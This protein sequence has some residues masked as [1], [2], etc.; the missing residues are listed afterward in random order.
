MAEKDFYSELFKQG[1]GN[2][3]SRGFRSQIT[4]L[5]LVIGIAAIVSL[6]SLGESLNEA[7]SG[8]FEQLGTNTLTVL[9]GK[10]FADTAFVK[11]MENDSKKIE[12]VRGV[13]YANDIFITTKQIQYRNEYKTTLVLGVPGDKIDSMVKIGFI[14]LGEGKLLDSR[15]KFATMIGANFA[16]KGFNESLKLR[17]NIK[18]DGVP[19][20]IIGINKQSKN[21]AGSFLNN[22]VIINNDTLQGISAV[23]ILPSRIMVKILDNYPIDFAKKDIIKVLKKNHDNTEDFQ[24]LD[25][26]QVAETAT[27]VIGLIQL[28]F[29]GIA[30]ISLLIGGI[31]IMNSML[32]SVT[33]RTSEIGLMKVLG[34]TDNKVLAI[35]LAE[36]ALVGIIGGII[37]ALLGTLLS[38]GIAVGAT[39][40]GFALPFSFNFQIIFGAILFAGIVGI[41]SGIVPARAAAKLEPVKAIRFK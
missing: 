5:A 16:E 30:F 9:P 38:L 4:I 19:F 11:L 26:R 18:I 7:V 21:L 24:V 23:K 34:A 20:Q 29:V 3:V 35:F 28:V 36:S 2:I 31:G 17:E 39:Q 14:E 37:G 22:A 12:G 41:V 32:M 8:Q 13:E 6:V 40:A 1:F 27:S 25:A 33:E 15:Q 10:S